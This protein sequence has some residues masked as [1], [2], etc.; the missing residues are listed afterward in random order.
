M[1]YL[2][3]SIVL[4]EEEAS[5]HNQEY[6]GFSTDVSMPSKVNTHCGSI[7]VSC[8]D[9]HSLQEAMNT[10]DQALMNRRV[11]PPVEECP[12]GYHFLL[13]KSQV[14]GLSSIIVPISDVSFLRYYLKSSL[15]EHFCLLENIIS[16][17]LWRNSICAIKNGSWRLLALIKTLLL[18]PSRQLK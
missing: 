5:S 9:S 11:W 13:P 14:A 2:R 10:S 8:E 7:A 15:C 16:C 6:C 1:R 12:W 3:N 4:T 17:S 18:S